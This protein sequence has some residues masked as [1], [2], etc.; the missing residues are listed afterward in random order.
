MAVDFDDC[1]CSGKSMRT[2]AAPWIL[3]AL[4]RQDGLHGYE[5]TKIVKGYMDELGVG[6]NITGLYRHLNHLEKRGMLVSEWDTRN[7]GPAKRNYYLTEDGRK[8]LWRWIQ[9]LSLQMSLIG[10]FFN[11]AKSVFPAARLPQVDLSALETRSNH[12]TDEVQEV[13]P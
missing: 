1:P 3:L 5:L 10:T 4:H 12:R 9:T 7:R 13:T 2:M 6:L 11:Q 8:C